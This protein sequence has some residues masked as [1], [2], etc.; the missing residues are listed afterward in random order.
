MPFTDLTPPPTAPTRSMTNDEFI[1]AADA[2]VAWMAEFQGDLTLF[3]AEL[4]ATA[5]LIAAAPAIADPGL[6]AMTGKTPA[7]DRFIYFTSASASAAD[8]FAFRIFAGS[9]RAR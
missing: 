3:I 2:F 9:K 1:D 4:E 6:V 5:A 7:A 8:L